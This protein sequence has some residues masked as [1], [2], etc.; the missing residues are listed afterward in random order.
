VGTTFLLSPISG[1]LADKFGIRQT[2]FMGGLIA[3]LGMLLSSFLV[4]QVSQ[5]N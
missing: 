3:S 2:V 1:M 4:D 5:Q